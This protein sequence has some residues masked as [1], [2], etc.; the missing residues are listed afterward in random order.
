M[1]RE[2]SRSAKIS[3]RLVPLREET[4]QQ[5]RSWKFHGEHLRRE[6]TSTPLFNRL[7]KWVGTW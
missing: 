5:E 4:N 3:K 7:G 2:W 1:Q 6:P